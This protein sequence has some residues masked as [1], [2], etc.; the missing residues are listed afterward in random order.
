MEDLQ[1][2]MLYKQQDEVTKL[3]MEPR[4][5]NLQ[6]Y[7]R[8]KNLQ[9]IGL[10]DCLRGPYPKK[11]TKF[12]TKKIASNEVSTLSGYSWTSVRLD[13]NILINK[14]CKYFVNGLA[15]L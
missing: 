5:L 15:R 8:R 12:W 13:R 3:K 7:S 1:F 6:D 2:K 11:I 4:L 10:K 9:I 14:I